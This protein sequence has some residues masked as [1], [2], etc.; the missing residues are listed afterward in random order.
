MKILGIDPGSIKTG[1]AVIKGKESRLGL[2]TGGFI[3]LSS[4]LSFPEK[5]DRINSRVTSLIENHHPDA[6]V[7]EGL[8]YQKNVKSALKLAHVRGVVLLAAAR[9][10]L[11]VY[12]Y[13]PGE[14][15]MA[16]SGNGRA[17]KN[18]VRKMV[19]RI[20]RV[21]S[22]PDSDDAS[23]AMAAAICHAHSL[24]FKKMIK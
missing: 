11:P 7:V 1:Y 8:F 5:L 15:K 24:R 23:D 9:A 6:L 16:V 10:G 14:I 18:Q 19:M 4:G 3:K 2:E 21:P 13:S 20:L 12:E 22:L 17:T